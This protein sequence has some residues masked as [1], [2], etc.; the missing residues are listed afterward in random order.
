MF[1]EPDIICSH[2][3]MFTLGISLSDQTKM[4]TN[5]GG[6]SS[7][8]FGFWSRFVGPRAIW[9]NHGPRSI[10]FPGEDPRGGSAFHPTLK[11]HKLGF[12]LALCCQ[13]K[14]PAGA[15]KT[16]TDLPRQTLVP[17]VFT[18]KLPVLT[19][20]HPQKNI[21]K[22][23]RFLTYPHITSRSC[24]RFQSSTTCHGMPAAGL[25]WIPSWNHGETLVG[26]AFHQWCNGVAEAKG[27]TQILVHHVKMVQKSQ[28]LHNPQCY[29]TTLHSWAVKSLDIIEP[30]VE[31]GTLIFA[32]SL[33]HL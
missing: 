15:V 33:E 25:P 14:A 4:G 3:H 8:K 17:L 20:V 5:K 22:I 19:D 23:T 29:V 16:R 13:P 21:P 26:P 11:T 12:P 28:H 9:T 10:L 6:R 27:G 32:C 31:L 1:G 30:T 2:Y 24:V 18:P 7:Q